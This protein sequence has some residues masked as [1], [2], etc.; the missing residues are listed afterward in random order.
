MREATALPSPAR[1]GVTLTSRK[2]FQLKQL[3]PPYALMALWSPGGIAIRVATALPLPASCWV[4]WI[5]RKLVL[6]IQ[7]LL[8]YALMA[9]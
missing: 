3:L 1:C 6:L 8:A 7:P 5:S 4:M 9:Q 2:F